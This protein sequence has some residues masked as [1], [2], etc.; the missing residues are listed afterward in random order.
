MEPGPKATKNPQCYSNV[1]T[2]AAPPG[3]GHPGFDEYGARAKARSIVE[4]YYA[5]F[6]AQCKAQANSAVQRPSPRYKPSYDA[7]DA[8]A[9]RPHPVSR[10]QNDIHVQM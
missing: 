6:E 4:G 8:E 10:D 7:N 3:Y 1:V 5:R 9:D 2:L